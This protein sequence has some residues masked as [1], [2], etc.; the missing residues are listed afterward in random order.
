MCRKNSAEALALYQ[1]A[2][3]KGHA[4]AMHNVAN[5]LVNGAAGRVDF[6]T[7]LALYRAA[8]ERGHADSLAN[9]G[10]M[11]EEG[12]GVTRNFAEA[13]RWYRAGV[14]RQSA[15]A[16]TLLGRMYLE[17]RGTAS[18]PKQ[19]LLLFQV[20]AAAEQ[21]PALMYLGWMYEQ[22]TGVERNMREALRWYRLAAERGNPAAHLLIGASLARDENWSEAAVSFQHAADLGD[23]IGMAQL[24]L[25]YS[26]GK[27][28]PPDA[29]R[30]V[31]LYRQSAE[32]NY[33]EGQALLAQAYHKGDGVERDYLRAREFYRRAAERNLSQAYFNYAMMLYEGRAGRS[34]MP[35]RSCNAGCKQ[36]IDA[37]LRYAGKIVSRWTR[38]AG[39]PGG[40]GA[41]HLVAA[42]GGLALRK[43]TQATR[44][45]TVW[46]SRGMLPSRSD[47]LSVP[48][49]KVNRTRCTASRGFT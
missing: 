44:P 49:T 36:R 43:T 15:F 6:A 35:A 20:G 34:T 10:R 12:R 33:P 17:G 11:Y 9:L 19:A 40:F 2:A 24:G 22:G 45:P 42:E 16:A 1:R 8:G 23:P 46:G 27:G 25:L 14:E 3:A 29:A 4:P 39:R 26:E 32:R 7:A 37:G 28:V 5:I 18:D 41:F 31:E 21:H 47:G 48:R 13:V 30:A 38:C